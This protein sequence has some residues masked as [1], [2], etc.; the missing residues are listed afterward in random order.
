[1]RLRNTAG[2]GKGAPVEGLNPWGSGL[3]GGPLA[4]AVPQVRANLAP[5]TFAKRMVVL[6]LCA[7]GSAPLAATHAT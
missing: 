1:M 5:G 2:S 3:L 6:G 7:N 4:C